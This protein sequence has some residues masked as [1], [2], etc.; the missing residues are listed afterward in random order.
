MGYYSL[1]ET[2]PYTDSFILEDRGLVDETLSTRLV[3]ALGPKYGVG[4]SVG[5]SLSRTGRVSTIILT[6]TNHTNVVIPRVY[7]STSNQ[8]SIMS[9]MTNGD[10]TER[11]LFTAPAFVVAIVGTWKIVFKIA[12]P[13]LCKWLKIVFPRDWGVFVSGGWIGDYELDIAN[14]QVF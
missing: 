3:P 12:T 6:G 2:S 4:N 9:S 5:V 1:S 10:Y 11:Q 14:I 8:F 7:N 13:F